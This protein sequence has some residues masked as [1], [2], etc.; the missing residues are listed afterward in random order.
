MS[1]PDDKNP[2]LSA[3]SLLVENIKEEFLGPSSKTDILTE[4]PVT[5]YAAGMLFPIDYEARNDKEPQT[6]EQKLDAE[7]NQ[8]SSEDESC[9]DD[10]TIGLSSSFFPSVLGISFY[11]LGTDP[12]LTVKINWTAYSKIDPSESYVDITSCKDGFDKLREIEEFKNFFALKDGKLFVNSDDVG[13][14]I[15]KIIAEKAA[16][17]NVKS[18]IEVAIAR[19]RFDSVWTNHPKEMVIN[20]E[21]GVNNYKVGDGLELI[22]NRRRGVGGS[23]LYTVAVKNTHPACP[24]GMDEEH[25]FFDVSLKIV[26]AEL[27]EDIFI[28]YPS[29]PLFS[30]DP[31][32]QSLALLYRNRKTYAVGHG[33]SANWINKPGVANANAVYTESLPMFE[34]PMLDFNV[35]GLD[36]EIL[37]MKYLSCE[38][39]TKRAE[40]IEKLKKFASFY[41]EWISKISK[42]KVSEGLQKTVAKHVSLC[43]ETDQRMK[44]GIK[45]LESNTIAMDAFSLANKAMLMQSVQTELQKGSS[46]NN[47]KIEDYYTK[48]AEEVLSPSGR[49]KW[50][51]F[52]LGFLLLSI[53][54]ILEQECN[55]RKLV[56]L[57]WFPTGGGKTEAYLGLSAF[58]I[59]YRRLKNKSA[60]TTVMMRYTLRLLTAQQFQRACTLICAM[61][62][63]RKQLV[64]KLGMDEISIGLWVGVESTPN[65]HE[66]A[67][68]RFG[69]FIRGESEKNPSPLLSCPWCGAKMLFEGQTGR[70]FYAYKPK[71]RPQRAALYCPDKN[72]DFNERLPVLIVDE[73]IYDFPPTLLFGTVD[74]FAQMPFQKGISRLFSVDQ[75]NP[76]MPPELIIQDELHLISSSLGTM[77]GIYE[78]AIDYLCSIKGLCPKIIASTAT[79]RRAPD[80]CRSLFNR[81]TRQ[82]PP[83]GI[84]ISDSFFSKEISTDVKPGRLYIGLMPS[85]K[86]QTTASIRL[87][88]SLLHATFAMHAENEVKDKYWTLVSYFNSIRELGGFISLLYDDIPLYANALK[89][90]YG[91][92]MRHISVER[93]LTSR[94]SAEDIPQ[95]L[96]QLSHNYPDQGTI[97][98]L[99]ATNMIS[100]G[101]DIDRLGLMMIRGQP[102]LTSEYIQVSSRIGRKYPG[103]VVTLYNSARTRDRAHYERF[104]T[105]HE[106]FY[107]NVEP[108]SVTPFSAPARTRALNAVLITLFRHGLGIS[109]YNGEDGASK[110]NQNL[111]GLQTIKKYISTRVKEVDPEE[112]NAT[113]EDFEK[114]IQ[115]WNAFLQVNKDKVVY[116]N[117]KQGITLTKN[118]DGIGSGLWSIPT[119]MRNVD[120]ECNVDIYDE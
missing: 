95:I 115:E 35:E 28:E 44:K 103:M 46:G 70:R 57:I 120:A 62:K 22:C 73:E 41:T 3:R 12:K 65:T 59:F 61:E 60:G 85:G 80:Q 56:D 55:D 52:Q 100:V 63:I 106:S 88:A 81:D 92:L 97:D 49:G 45:I 14:E 54:G 15:P 7:T 13:F 83:P 51:P 84:E 111:P 102:K 112:V 47:I 5:R 68:K 66:Q 8:V 58:T 64:G 91:G 50:R 34:V 16:N 48:E 33:C 107:R 76:N 2:Y 74:K 1:N 32:E 4:N 72:C 23:T 11:T 93:E 87:A 25:V 77:V 42:I 69:E 75:G 71:S 21:K 36:P 104:R 110:F 29:P 40:V 105:Y 43:E 37:S 27:N 26:S 24:N 116:K 17:N 94:K 98:V 30:N 96:E 9:M 19:R 38:Q 53:Q 39:I 20:I 18:L 99:S 108:S 90:R 109:E 78:T 117:D 6:Q 113:L 118:Y 119:S 82:F 89:Q 114:L 86:T 31:E 79:V 10:L 101:I 67:K